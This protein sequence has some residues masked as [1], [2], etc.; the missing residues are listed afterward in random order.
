MVTSVASVASIGTVGGFTIVVPPIATNPFSPVMHTHT[1]AR[2]PAPAPLS[3]SVSVHRRR[4][5]R[6]GGGGGG[7][8][9]NPPRSFSSV[10]RYADSG[11]GKDASDWGV[12]EAALSSKK[13]KKNNNNNNK[14]NAHASIPFVISP[15]DDIRY[16]TA[17][18]VEEQ[19]PGDEDDDSNDDYN[20][21]IDDEIL[22]EIESSN[23]AL[24]TDISAAI[25]EVL[26]APV[27]PLGEKKDDANLIIPVSATTNRENLGMNSKSEPTSYENNP[28]RGSNPPDRNP[29]VPRLRRWTNSFDPGRAWR[30]LRPGQKF[31]VRLGL[32]VL[33]FVSLWN[34]V[35]V[36]SSSIGGDGGG[37][38][39][40]ILTG[41]AAT[42]TATGFGATLRRWLSLR[43]FQGI[44][45]LGRSIAYG[46][47][48]LVAYPRMLDR[49]AK[50]RR[51]KKEEE[52]LKQWRQVLKGIAEEVVRLKRELSLLEGE[53]RA[54]RREILAIRAARVGERRPNNNSS[55]NS[56]NNNNS[57]SNN[58]NNNNNMTHHSHRHNHSHDIDDAEA[59]PASSSSSSDE[60][61]RV[62]RDAI[63]HE[64]NHLTRLRDDTRLALT[65]ARQR[66][67]DVRAKR[68]ILGAF[69]SNPSALDPLEYEFGALPDLDFRY[70][71]RDIRNDDLLLRGL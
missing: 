30:T 33:A 53:I 37:W 65:R 46:W 41:A 70:E 21:Y 28:F 31:R 45:A 58:N 52:A 36:G 5:T 42:T 7:G 48:I 6:S 69:K 9:G 66:W 13:K 61:D 54:F 64:M 4:R 14:K 8:G 23:E 39:G 35:L 71:D 67:S 50:D 20:K 63:L 10:L 49:R 59:Q 1:H 68:P 34:T 18:T 43:G 44:A 22:A 29:I 17:T 25:Q 56:N 40:G 12:D 26:T 51:A 47:A 27:V 57:N 2:A 38:I 24:P 11:G 19:E 60:S 55:N 3:P 15:D 16:R 62:L 32:A